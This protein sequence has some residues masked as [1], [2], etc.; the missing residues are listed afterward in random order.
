[1]KP[2][3]ERGRETNCLSKLPGD[4]LWCLGT[5]ARPG[6]AV[7]EGRP[8]RRGRGPSPRLLLQ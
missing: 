1:M 6:G 3:L 8:K 7:C 4:V 2:A 5:P